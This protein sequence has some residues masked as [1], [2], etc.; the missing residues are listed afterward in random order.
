MHVHPL[1][2]LPAKDRGG[3]DDPAL[4]FGRL[5]RSPGQGHSRVVELFEAGEDRGLRVLLAWISSVHRGMLPPGDAR[6]A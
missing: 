3:Q 4:V 2:E 6:I 5:V 1:L